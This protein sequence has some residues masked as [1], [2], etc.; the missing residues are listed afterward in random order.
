MIDI[1]RRVTAHLSADGR[2]GYRGLMRCGN[3]WTCPLCGNEIAARQRDLL[4]RLHDAAEAVGD[5]GV[6]LTLTMRHT[7]GESLDSMFR[8]LREALRA[9]WKDKRNRA[10]LTQYGY[11]GRVTGMEVTYGENG[12]HLHVHLTVY[13]TTWP[14]DD[15]EKYGASLWQRCVQQAGGYAS[16]ARGF[17]L[18]KRPTE[19]DEENPGYPAKWD[20]ASELSNPERKKSEGMSPWALLVAAQDSTTWRA[21]WEEYEKATF[22]QTRLKL[23][24]GLAAHYGIDLEENDSAADELPPEEDQ[25]DIVLTMGDA[26]WRSVRWARAEAALLDALEEGGL[27]AATALLHRIWTDYA[28]AARRAAGPPTEFRYPAIGA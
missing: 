25:G 19:R 18:T 2:A 10:L 16:K 21:L 11:T 1:D 27:E 4:D 22:R 3:A 26:T 23:S 15:W 8:R 20:L 14:G 6:L 28:A 13:F 12:W 7:R 5:S 17:L 24:P 9:F